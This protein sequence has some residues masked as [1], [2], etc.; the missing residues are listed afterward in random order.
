MRILVE[1]FDLLLLGRRDELA[2]LYKV[3]LVEPVLLAEFANLVRVLLHEMLD[4]HFLDVLWQLCDVNLRALEFHAQLQV[5]WVDLVLSIVAGGRGQVRLPS[6]R[7][8][9]FVAVVLL[10]GLLL[11]LVTYLAHVPVPSLSLQRHQHFSIQ[12]FPLL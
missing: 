7:V 12:S 11:A 1:F 3:R 9:Q 5:S 10:H 4:D 6:C 2:D 8:L